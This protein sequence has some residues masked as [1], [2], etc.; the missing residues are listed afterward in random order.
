MN[1]DLKNI[2]LVCVEGTQKE[3]NTKNAHDALIVSSRNIDFAKCLLLS[4]I[5]YTK[6]SKIQHQLINPFSW[7]GYNQFIVHHLNTYIDTDYCIIIQSDGFIL[8]SHLWIDE[9]LYYD[10]IGHSFD[11]Q[12]YPC[13]VK[14]VNPEIVARK[15][16]AGLNRVG[17]GGFSMRS[18]KLLELSEK[19]TVQCNGPEDAFICND[20]YDYFVSNGVKFAPVELADKFSKDYGDYRNDTF[21]FHGNKDILQQIKDLH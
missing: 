5:E 8:N 14:G 4:P 21:G 12:R 16:V 9:F 7:I 20:N 3:Q 6:T 10:Y 11:F 15:G 2:T 1:L 13:Q 17:N 19:I 18:K